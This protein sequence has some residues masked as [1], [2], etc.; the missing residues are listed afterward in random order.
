[1]LKIINKFKF[2]KKHLLIVFLAS[3]LVVLSGV[4][5]N[6]L[7]LNGKFEG[8]NKTTYEL[9]NQNDKDKEQAGDVA[10]VQEEVK[11]T[12]PTNTPIPTVAPTLVQPKSEEQVKTVYPTLAPQPTPQPTPTVDNSARLEALR[13]EYQ[14]TKDYYMTRALVLDAERNAKIQETS[15]N[16]ARE[17]GARGI[18]LSSGMYQQELA[19]ITQSINNYYDGL[20]IQ[21][22]SEMK[23]KLSQIES[24][25]NSIN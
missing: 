12:T 22:D 14:A 19:S 1:M 24:E 5:V 6:K 2:K 4:A 25:I 9:I 23:M 21:L 20:I 17:Y 16:L 10:G 7:Y 8:E 11:A 18:P 3:G 15:R 13:R